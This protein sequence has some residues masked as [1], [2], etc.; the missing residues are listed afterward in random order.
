MDGGYP[1]SRA[2]NFSNHVQQWF[3]ALGKIAYLSGPI[4]HLSIDIG[5]IITVPRRLHPVIPDALKIGR[6][7][8][9]TRAAHEQIAAILK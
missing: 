5:C 6:L 7:T 8:P 9:R 3:M 2:G 1:P 4:V